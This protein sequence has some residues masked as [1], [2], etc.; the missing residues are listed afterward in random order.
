MNWCIYAALGGDAS[1]RGS[2][3]KRDT[4]KYDPCWMIPCPLAPLWHHWSL[5]CPCRAGRCLL[6]LW[7]TSIIHMIP[8]YPWTIEVLCFYNVAFLITGK[9]HACH[10]VSNHRQL[11]SWI[12][13]LFRILEQ[14][15]KHQSSTL[16]T[17]CEGN[18]SVVNW[19]IPLTKGQ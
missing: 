8:L 17:L 19:W 12:N 9:S 7:A 1:L 3:V 5:N 14:Q 4:G 10:C 6:P 16:L 2:W 18:M 11:D 15:R 13:R